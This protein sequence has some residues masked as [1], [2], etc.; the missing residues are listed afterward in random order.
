M[1][2]RLYTLLAKGEKNKRIYMDQFIENFYVPLFDSPPIVKAQFM[3]KML[4]FDGDGYLHAYDLVEAQKL[5]DELSDFDQEI[6]K[7]NN[8]YISTYLKSL[9]KMRV[10]DQINLHRYKDLLDSSGEPQSVKS[11]M[12]TLQAK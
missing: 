8:Y 12:V 7:L 3:F 1:D 6:T 11:N 2:A 5:V 10:H 4:D 9:T